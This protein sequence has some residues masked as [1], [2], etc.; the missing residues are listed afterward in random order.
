MT[1]RVDP[2]RRLFV[3]MGGDR[4]HGGGLKVFTLDDGTYRVNDWTEAA[5][6]SADCAAMLDVAGPSV[7][8][9]TRRDLFV[10]WP[11][12][13]STVYLFDPGDPVGNFT[14]TMRTPPSA[15]SGVP[16]SPPDPALGAY[17]R[18]RYFP[19][20]DGFVGVDN[21]DA[22]AFALRFE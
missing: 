4:T 18:F 2:K 15:S 20:H 6:S 13:G 7:A 8:Y 5:I 9:D 16:P 21:A 22:D 3:L 19:D 17:G 12:T 10:V 14:C 11:N 1:G